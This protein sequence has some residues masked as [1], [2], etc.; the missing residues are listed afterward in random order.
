MQSS[1]FRDS[2]LEN[3]ENSYCR[4]LRKKRYFPVESFTKEFTEV[5][6]LEFNL[7]NDFVKHDVYIYMCGC[8]SVY[9]MKYRCNYVSNFEAKTRNVILEILSSFVS[10][11][12][13]ESEKHKVCREIET[14]VEC[15]QQCKK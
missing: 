5:P 11:C 4:W 2:F 1:F 8:V 7:S 3:Y 9:R 15:V 12:S 6:S 14:R 13:N 10:L